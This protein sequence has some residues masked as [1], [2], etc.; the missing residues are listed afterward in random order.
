MTESDSRLARERA[1]GRKDGA[2]NRK[3]RERVEALLDPGSFLEVGV[4]ARDLTHGRAE[5]SPAD[6]L[7]AGYG[8]VDGH[9]VGVLSL[10]GAVLAGSGGHAASAKQSRIIEEAYLHRFPLI[11]FGEGGGGRIPDMMNSALG[12]HG[13]LAR[14]RTN[15]LMR[16]AHRDRPFPLISCCM[17][18]M[19]GDPSFKLGLADFPL[20]VKDACLGVSGPPVIRA[21]LGEI[22]SGEELGGSHVHAA[23]GQIARVEETEADVLATVRRILDFLLVARRETSDAADRATPEIETIL[24]TNYQRAYDVRKIVTAIVDQD[25]EPLELWPEFGP[26]ARAYFARLDG[27]AIAIFANNPMVRGG[28]FDVWS[29]RK[30]SKLLERCEK[31]RIP[32]LYLHDT[33]GFII[34]KHAEADGLLGHAMQYVR[35]LAS[36]TVPKLSLVLRK[37]YG[38]AYFAMAGP[39]WGG[40]YVAAL[41]SARIAFMGAGPGINLVYEKKLREAENRDA[42]LAR[43]TA[44]WEER[45]EPWEAAFVSSV[46]D[47]LEPAES[48][49]KLIQALRAFDI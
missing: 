40:D 41:P 23:N 45:A 6:A 16:L 37:S 26:T 17:G 9:R 13:A 22:V 20:M 28:V 36:T 18:E 24:P 7:I 19:Y 47:I 27:R 21:A 42:E 25:C 31:F 43:L 34:G 2:P 32:M 3:A 15:V 14:E 4:L 5:K 38:L 46:D 44:E 1:F 49:Q 29:A 35:D 48:R 10:D 8:T 11:T 33:P 39:G 30:G 12:Q